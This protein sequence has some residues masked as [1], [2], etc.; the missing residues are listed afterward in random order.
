MLPLSPNPVRCH[1]VGPLVSD[2]DCSACDLGYETTSDNDTTCVKPAFRP[3]RGWVANYSRM[4]LRD[5]RDS[6]IERNPSTDARASLLL[7]EHTYE[8]PAPRLTPKV[9]RFAGYAQPHTKI[10][11]E[12]DF[13]RGAE[14]DLGCGTTVVGDTTHDE[15]ISQERFAHP[16]SMFEISYQFPAGRGT[17]THDNPGSFP[18]RG[19]CDLL[20]GL[21]VHSSLC[22]IELDA[23]SKAR[24]TSRRHV[25]A[26]ADPCDWARRRSLMAQPFV[27]CCWVCRPAFSS[28]QGH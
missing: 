5:T 4:R 20:P 14:V 17:R 19:Q 16:S 18:F 21:C 22:S 28:F 27:F 8:I 9:R 2:L 25:P 10:H 23:S 6:G 12:L 26:V 15:A 3:Y 1:W 24:G 13:S 11:Y 7:T